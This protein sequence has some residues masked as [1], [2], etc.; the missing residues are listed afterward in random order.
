MRKLSLPFSAS[1]EASP[2]RVHSSLSSSPSNSQSIPDDSDHSDDEYIDTI[3]V[4]FNL[5][6]IFFSKNCDIGA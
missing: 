5:Q 3:D 2:Q 6:K 4:S 1:R